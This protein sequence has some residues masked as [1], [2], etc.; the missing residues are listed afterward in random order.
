M[1]RRNPRR[2]VREPPTVTEQELLNILT[3]AMK[4]LG[5]DWSPQRPALFFLEVQDEILR[6]WRSPIRPEPKPWDLFFFPLVDSRP[7]QKDQEVFQPLSRYTDVWRVLPG[8][9]D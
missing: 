3:E 2:K 9:S 1:R 4:Y 8:V 7:P 5:L 6:S